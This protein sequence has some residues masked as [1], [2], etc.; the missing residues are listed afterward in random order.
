MLSL[1]NADLRVVLLILQF[2]DFVSCIDFTFFPFECPGDLIN[3]ANI[4]YV[5]RCAW[6]S[7]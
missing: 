1:Q 4:A 5:G 7:K 2:R 3:M 6:N